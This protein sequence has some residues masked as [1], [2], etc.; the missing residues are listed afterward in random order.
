MPIT[1]DQAIREHNFHENK[2]RANGSCYNWRR[3]GATKLWKRDPA[4]FQVPVKYGLRYYGYITPA[5]AENFH[6]PTEG[7]K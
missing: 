7:C 4:R 5:N 2:P 1:R 6:V 3:N